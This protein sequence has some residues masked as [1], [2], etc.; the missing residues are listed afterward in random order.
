MTIWDIVRLTKQHDRTVFDC[1]E[2]SL[3]DWLKVRAG[4]YDRKDMS[5][6]FVA[7]KDGE[8]LVLGYYALAT[9]SVEPAV[10]PLEQAKGLP[11]LAVPVAL[12]ARLAVDQA[13]QGLGLGSFLLIDALRRIVRIA[14][15]IGIRAIEVD[16]LNES[17]KAFYLKFGF[18]ELLDDPRHLFIPLHEVRKLKLD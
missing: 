18:R 3:N 4:Q 12:L 11:P 14:E 10:M 7:T 8:P 16:A 5:R 13:A 1:G 9:H 2:P 6:T 17:A 15:Q